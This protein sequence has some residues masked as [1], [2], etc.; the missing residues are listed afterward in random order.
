MD[1]PKFI[2]I[3]TE[4][5]GLAWS[6]SDRPFGIGIH[7][8]TLSS[9]VDFPVDPTNRKVSTK[10]NCEKTY[11]A[12]LAQ[13]TDPTLEKVFHNAKFDLHMLDTIGI[14]V[15]G[16]IH[17]TYIAARCC[18]TLEE[19]YKLKQL[20]SKYLS[21]ETDD[22]SDLQKAVLS[23][24]RKAIASNWAIH[25][26]TAADYWLPK[27]VDPTSTLCEKY[28]KL[29]CIRTYKLWEMYYPLLRE[30]NVLNSYE[31]ELRLIPI[32]RKMEAIGV[33]VDAEKVMINIA[34]LKKKLTGIEHAIL[35]A[36]GNPKLNINSPKQL[37]EYLFGKTGLRL[38]IKT[39]TNAGQPS[40]SA[41]TLREYKDNPV[42]D[43]ILQYR[44]IEKGLAFFNNYV[45]QMVPDK[46]KT[47]ADLGTGQWS[48]FCI[49]P[50]F[51]QFGARTARFS[52]NDPNLQNVPDPE[53]S[54]GEYV[55]DVREIFI[56][57]NGFTWHAFD[58]KQLEA[59]IF[60]ERACEES[61]LEAF[62]LGRDLHEETGRK[63]YGDTLS[64]GERRKLAKNIFFC[65]IFAGGP[66]VLARRY[67]ITYQKAK[68]M[69]DGYD[70][71]FP[72][73]K[74][75]IQTMSNLAQQQGYIINAYNRKI[76][77]G[78]KHYA[79]CN[80]DVQSSAA[81]LM[82]RAMI[83]IDAYLSR[84]RLCDHCIMLLTIHDE[85]MFEIRNGYDTKDLVHDLSEIMADNGGVFPVGTPVSHKV[86]I[87][88]WSNKKELELV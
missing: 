13:I 33:R 77:T 18:N 11:Y 85:L 30:F 1:I 19:N 29:D 47:L 42:I 20:S 17:D 21:I 45:G 27:A 32:I 72:G 63:A 59:R 7:D 50:S 73:I 15:A 70:K 14:A 31:K 53:T 8:G 57:R 86:C 56:P 37:G 5:T 54:A 4:T 16:K 35:R 62:R 87:G 3:D 39:K 82:K 67:K 36:S 26:V 58:Y 43:A 49:H 41:D 66:G 38:P 44:G 40:V 74:K 23:A 84:E 46:T 83:A 22:E 25:E 60:A 64:P 9:Y 88:N 75:H 55:E 65:K 24:R 34:E 61:L 78:E 71:M 68:D 6:K 79:A 52:A 28:C 2:T 10:P 51:N 81:D 48:F 12:I 80:Y 76:Q 69:M